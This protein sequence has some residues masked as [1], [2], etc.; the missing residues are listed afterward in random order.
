MIPLPGVAFREID[1]TEVINDALNVLLWL[2]DG[3]LISVCVPIAELIQRGSVVIEG[4]PAA[5][6][7]RV[8]PAL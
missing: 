2:D 1:S 3:S 7:F 8:V 5:P 4:A 6:A